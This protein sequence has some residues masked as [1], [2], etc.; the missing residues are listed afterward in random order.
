M[1]YDGI[2]FGSLILICLIK[3]VCAYNADVHFE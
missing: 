1:N 3:K 2:F